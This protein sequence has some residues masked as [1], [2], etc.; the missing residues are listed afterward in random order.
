MIFSS[1]FNFLSTLGVIIFAECYNIYEQGN[2]TTPGGY[3]AIQPSDL[4]ISEVIDT[5]S[6]TAALTIS[7]DRVIQK[8][9]PLLR[10]ILYVLQLII[11]L[12]LGI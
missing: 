5:E 6:D 9:H 4:K 3:A 2:A 7:E 10:I 12:K 8:Q 1:C 11:K